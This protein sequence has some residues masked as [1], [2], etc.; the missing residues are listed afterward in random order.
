MHTSLHRAKKITLD[1]VEP[2]RANGATEGPVMSYVRHI[3]IEYEKDARLELV[4]HSDDPDDLY[5]GGNME[6]KKERKT[7]ASIRRVMEDRLAEEKLSL[8]AHQADVLLIEARIEVIMELLDTADANG[9]EEGTD[10]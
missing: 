3:R 7:A 6:Q 9:K 5:T 4:F 8:A 10:E 1:P 2:L